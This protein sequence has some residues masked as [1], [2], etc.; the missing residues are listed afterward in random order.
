MAT[1]E[2]ATE[3][4]EY[5]TPED[6]AERMGTVDPMILDSNNKKEVV[7]LNEAIQTMD[8]YGTPV[9]EI[10]ATKVTLSD[11]IAP[12]YLSIL[13][14]QVKA[15]TYTEQEFGEKMGQ[16]RHAST[17]HSDRIQLWWW[18]KYHE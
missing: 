6:E 10:T 1:E 16:K 15:G 3:T 2:E 13:K 4:I 12:K 14:K 18:K 5:L 11:T 7:Q 17:D 9:Q 8:I